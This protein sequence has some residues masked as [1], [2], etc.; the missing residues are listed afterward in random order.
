MFNRKWNHLALGLLLIGCAAAKDKAVAPLAAP[1]DV[2]KA[3]PAAAIA[4]AGAGEEGMSCA[5]CKKS[6]DSVAAVRAAISEALGSGDAAKMKSAL[7]R[8]DAQL[9]KMEEHKQKCHGMMKEADGAADAPEA[10][11]GDK[12]AEAHNHH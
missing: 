3:A 7:E 11:P 1:K 8:A 5:K 9:G 4:P 2:E 6:K 10:A 12:P